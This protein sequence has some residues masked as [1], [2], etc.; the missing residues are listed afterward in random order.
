MTPNGLRERKKHRTARL[1][2]E[3]ALALF[4]SKG[5]EGT[6]IAE[7][8][9]AAEVSP[10]TFFRYF[11]SKEDVVFAGPAR[12][13]QKMRECLARRDPR[14]S[15]YQALR[16]ALID[17][18][19][20]PESDKEVVMRRWSVIISHRRLLQRFGDEKHRWTTTLLA[21]L[22][23]RNN[24]PS[25]DLVTR[26]IVY[27]AWGVLAAAQE[28][29]ADDDARTPFPDLVERGFRFLEEDLELGVRGGHSA[30]IASS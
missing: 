19:H 9:E 4:E 11:D 5:F 25:P 12:N 6:T 23:A 21:D 1:L 10:R 22:V 28:A 14:E 15:D 24:A 2:E 27:T 3:K 18:S 29:W 13:L 7:I 20:W 16:N 30:S 17:Y 8:A 26:V